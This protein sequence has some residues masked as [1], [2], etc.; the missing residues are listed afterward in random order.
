M[1]AK[2]HVPAGAISGLLY[3][4]TRPG[5][6]EDYGA[7]VEWIGATIGGGL[8]ALVP[9][10]LEPAIHPLHRSTAHS[11]VAMSGVIWMDSQLQQ[12]QIKIREK[13][14]EYRRCRELSQNG[15]GSFLFWMGEMLCFAFAGLIAGILAGYVSHLVLD[16]VTPAGLPLLARGF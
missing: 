12:W 16:L 13:A 1:N 3:G 6:T 15:F 9:D 10:L 11:Y 5:Q 7:L 8:G 2:V 14:L 4:A